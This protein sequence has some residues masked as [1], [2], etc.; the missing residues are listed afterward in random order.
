MRI[1]NI[2]GSMDSYFLMVGQGL[3]IYWPIGIIFICL[4]LCHLS[5]LRSYTVRPH[6]QE[7]TCQLLTHNHCYS[8]AYYT[9]LTTLLV[10]SHLY[11]SSSPTHSC[12]YNQ[13]IIDTKS[14][15][16]I[17]PSPKSQS[18]WDD[19]KEHK[20]HCEGNEIGDSP[21]H[22]AANIP[23]KLCSLEETGAVWTSTKHRRK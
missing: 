16:G 15:L 18:N 2:E 14:S 22:C 1:L 8:H 17:R 23:N 13:G 3:R 20:Y 10:R 12:R 5:D 6:R 7:R 9:Y 19:C 11:Q 4:V 21:R